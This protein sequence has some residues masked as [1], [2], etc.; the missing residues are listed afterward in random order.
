[1]AEVTE[2]SAGAQTTESTVGAIIS[3]PIRIE[4][5]PEPKKIKGQRAWAAPASGAMALRGFLSPHPH[6]DREVIFVRV[7]GK[8][9]DLPFDDAAEARGQAALVS[10]LVDFGDDSVPSPLAAFVEATYLFGGWGR[11]ANFQW[12]LDWLP[13]VL[14]NA[15]LAAVLLSR[16][17]PPRNLILEMAGTDAFTMLPGPT[18]PEDIVLPQLQ[19]AYASP[20][21][22]DLVRYLRGLAGASYDPA[23]SPTRRDAAADRAQRLAAA[24]KL[25]TRRLRSR[26]YDELRRVE[27]A[28]SAAAQTRLE[29]SRRQIL[30]QGWRLLG[31]CDNKT[32]EEWKEAHLEIKGLHTPAT[33]DFAALEELLPALDTQARRLLDAQ[34]K[35]F[36]TL[37]DKQFIAAL[38]SAGRGVLQP[39]TLGS[40]TAAVGYFIEQ[41]YEL[42]RTDEIKRLRQDLSD[43]QVAFSQLLTTASYRF[44]ILLRFRVLDFVYQKDEQSPFALLPHHRGRVYLRLRDAL[45]AVDKMLERLRGRAPLSDDKQPIPGDGDLEDVLARRVK[46][47]VW[48]YRKAVLDG[49]AALFVPAESLTSVATQNM[50]HAI[51]QR[52]AEAEQIATA[53]SV[54]ESSVVAGLTMICPPAGLALDLAFGVADVVIAISVYDRQSDEYNCSLNPADSLADVEPSM[55]PVAMAFAGVVLSVAFP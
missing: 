19:P 4:Y 1:V 32:F 22:L 30:S 49:L 38:Q 47:S 43:E 46:D 41:V 2:K 28:A 23:P 39:T 7:N 13:L 8:M 44:P 26:V 54:G 35:L 18:R 15:S 51:E 55:M 12:Q 11:V 45:E 33:S 25:E 37:F 24:L 52:E 10:E 14:A 5:A 29:R 53:I 6:V 50:L 42:E 3:L 34:K 21:A 16:K 36:D 40:V 17:P 48:D 20:W 31:E 27:V 9:L